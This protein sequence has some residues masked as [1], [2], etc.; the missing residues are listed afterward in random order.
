MAVRLN[1][2]SVLHQVLRVSSYGVLKLLPIS[3]R[4]A[5][6][7]QLR[8]DL[9]PYSL[10]S[11]GATV[12]QI[13]AP[14]DL[15]RVGRSRAMQFS[16]FVGPNG[17]VIVI[18][19][20]PDNTAA[21]DAHIAGQRIS[22]VTLIRKGAWSEAT[23]L[24]FLSSPDHPAA[25]LVEGVYDE[26]RTDTESYKTISIPVDTV[27]NMLAGLDVSRIDLLSITTNGSERE[28]LKG[29]GPYADKVQ[30]LSVVGDA[31]N[32]DEIGTLGFEYR[33]VDDRG[34]LFERKA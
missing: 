3:W 32:F 6:G 26:T 18:E 5:I 10:L 25:S 30:Y 15:I 7:R 16:H 34:H 20:D 19:P 23:E 1:R 21:I 31:R 11:D 8:R 17:R 24:T 9:E 33:G 29:L 12:V 2:F 4:Y 27:E 22:N 13:G 28:I 14:W